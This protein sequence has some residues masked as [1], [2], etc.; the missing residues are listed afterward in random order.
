MNEAYVVVL[1]KPNRVNFWR[2]AFTDASPRWT[3]AASRATT[4]ASRAEAL[5]RLGQVSGS[6]VVRRSTALRMEA[7][8]REME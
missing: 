4:F 2:E 3:R 6:I 5:R 7:D 8:I 1:V